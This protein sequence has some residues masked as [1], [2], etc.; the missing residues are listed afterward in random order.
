MFSMKKVMV[1]V[2]TFL[3]LCAVGLS[4]VSAKTV[5]RIVAVVGS[6]VVFSSELDERVMMTRMQFPELKDDGSLRGKVLNSIIDQKVILAKA[7]IDSTGIDESALDGLVAERMKL[8]A[9][10]FSS[11]EEMES[12]FGKSSLMI[13]KELRQEIK[14]QQLVESLRRKKLSGVSV[15]HEETIAFYDANKEKL[16]IVPEGVSVSQILRYPDV[17]AESRARSKALIENVQAELKGGADFAA[18]AKKY[19][20]DPGSAPLGGDLGFVQRGELIQ[21]F[22]DAAYALKEGQVSGIVETRYGFHL[23]QLLDREVNSLHVRH[24]LIG[25]DRSKSDEAGTISL[26]RSIRSDVLSGKAPFADMARKYS[27]DPVSAKLGGA[28]LSSASMKTVFPLSTLRSPLKE[29]IGTL[30]KSGDISEP[31]KIEPPQ[32]EPFYAIFQ[33]N[34]KISAHR[35]NPAQDYVQLESLALESKKQQVY[36]AWVQELRREITIRK[37]DI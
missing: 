10:R 36:E 25:F 21:S 16:P 8:L 22:E 3:F 32:G 35:L 6:E 33:L 15:T 19:S 18:L 26:L 12:R 14:N 9:S 11:K 2:Y 23:I 13:R 34:D 31:V 17:T 7:R 30:K 5:D 29:I 28:V 20:Q 27:E 4:P 24:I 1:S 37:S